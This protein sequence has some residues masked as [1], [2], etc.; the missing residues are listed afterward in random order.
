MRC[1]DAQKIIDSGSLE[2]L[3]ARL[4]AQGETLVH[5][6]GCFDIVH[7]GHIHHLRFA[8]DQGDRLLIS[9]TPDRYV[10]KGPDRPMFSEQLRA[11][12]LAALE[13]VDWVVINDNPTAEQLLDCVRPDIY[14]KGAE[15]QNNN[16][17]R[18]LREKDIVESHGGRVVFSGDDVVFSSTALI[19]SVRAISRSHESD[20]SLIS[21][22]QQH[23]LT[24]RAIRGIFD[25]STGKRVLVLAESI[26]DIYAHCELP[27]IAQEHPMLS[28]H[29][30]REESFDGGGAIIA[31][32]LAAMGLGVTLCSPFG[33]DRASHEMM[34][35]ISRTGIDVERIACDV[36]MATK[37]RYLVNGEK[38]MKIN[39]STRY[40]L[41]DACVEQIIEH[42][43]SAGGYDAVVIAD[44]GLGLFA[45]RLASR[46][47]EGIRPHVGLIL[48]DVSGRRAQLGEMRGADVLCPCEV[49]LRQMLGSD[50]RPIVE[51]AQEAKAITRAQSLCVTR[52]GDGLLLLDEEH[53]LCGLP[54]MCLSPADVL[55][56]G[57]ALLAAMT[58]SL[59]GG[60][61]R[62]QAAYIGS[63]AAAIEGEIVGNMPVSASQVIERATSIG[64][65]IADGPGV[66]STHVLE[67]RIRNA[68]AIE[69]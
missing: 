52:A 54:A 60:G 66:K 26:I 14:I 12:N 39:S 69:A 46:V 33:D 56:C 47:I 24:T 50:D 65:I 43:R 17:L 34:G 18:F 27:E 9:I 3:R 28:L 13:F 41:D 8:A 48:G 15:Y 58:A 37:V 59:V 45:N 67:P 35:R 55:G 32:H 5:C 64:A 4:R 2:G 40:A 20:A 49:E 22:S 29:P 42:V 7:P 38:M 10:N 6:H 16:D 61:D 31:S 53:G 68:S 1:R 21:L 51:L 62:I 57:D 36:S 30:E 63:L 23:D 44:F 11:D 25:T 19:D